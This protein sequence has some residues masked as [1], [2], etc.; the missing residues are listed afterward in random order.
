MKQVFYTFTMIMLILCYSIGYAA[1]P[2][3]DIIF[4]FPFDEG[5]GGTTTDVSANKFK[6]TIKNA[7]WVQGVAG[8]ALKLIT[9]QLL[10][11]HLVLL[12]PPI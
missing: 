10:C 9:V 6:G 3:E 11:P 1:N 2:A 5:N 7:E 4:H 12:N 8:Q